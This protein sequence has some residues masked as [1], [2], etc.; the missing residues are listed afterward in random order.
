MKAKLILGFLTLGAILFSVAYLTRYE[1]FK[2][3]RYV[4]VQLEFRTN[5]YTNETDGLNNTGWHVV[6]TSGEWADHHWKRTHP[7]VLPPLPAAPTLPAPE[8]V[9]VPIPTQ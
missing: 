9:P 8:P 5:R 7:D 3:G 1:Y 2:V 6:Q 4:G